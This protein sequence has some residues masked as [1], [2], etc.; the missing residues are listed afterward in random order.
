MESKN[1]VFKN[2]IIK[3]KKIS[4][5]LYGLIF[6]ISTMVY[7][8]VNIS[9]AKDL[10]SLT[11]HVREADFYEEDLS[12]ELNATKVDDK[13]IITLAPNQDGQVVEKYLIVSKDKFYDG[14]KLNNDEKDS[15]IEEKQNEE[16]TVTQENNN[17]VSNSSNTISDTNTVIVQGKNI[18]T[19]TNNVIATENNTISNST[20][21]VAKSNNTNEISSKTGNEKSD[22]NI[23]EKNE[24]TEQTIEVLPNEEIELTEDQI[25]NKEVYVLAIY[26]YREP[27]EDPVPEIIAENSQAKAPIL[28]APS[29][30]E[31]DETLTINDYYSDYYYYKGKNYTENS[32]GTNSGRYTD[33]N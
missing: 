27:D 29:P 10:L 9:Q 14:V 33:S 21:V 20:N 15:A 4:V 12:Y 19:D 2:Q 22:T 23:V 7:Y 1:I 31:P 17:T 18:V 26:D 24:V 3:K 11:V 32:S 8:F 5:V 13:Y 28:R 16:K 30:T 25:E 6:L